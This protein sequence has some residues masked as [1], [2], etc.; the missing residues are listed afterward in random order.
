VTHLKIT[1]SDPPL[2][3]FSD[4]PRMIKLKEKH[5]GG[6][7]MARAKTMTQLIEIL[8]RLKKGESIRNIKKETGTHRKVIRKVKEISWKKEWL[9][10]GTNLPSEAEMNSAY[11]EPDKNPKKPHILD[12]YKEELERYL[13]KGKSFVVIHKLICENAACAGISEITVR[14][15]I[16]KHCSKP[17]VPVMIR[18]LEDAVMEVDFGYLGIVFDLLEN[19][20]KKAWVF[21]GRLRKSRKAYREI[22]YNQKNETFFQCHNRAFHHFGGVPKK[23]VPDNLKS[24]VVEAAFYDPIINRSYQE[25]AKHYNFLISPCL[26]R[27]PQHKGGVENDIKYIKNNFWPYFSEKQAQ[28]GRIVPLSIELEEELEK[29]DKETANVRTIKGV[30]ASPEEL[31]T[32][33]RKSLLALPAEDWDI[34]N[35]KKCIVRPE[36]MIQYD[37]AYYSVPYRY[38]GKEVMVCADS[39]AVRV[40]YEYNLIASHQRAQRKW[41]YKRNSLHAPIHQEEYL[42]ETSESLL[43]WA[44]SIG[45]SVLEVAE[46]ILS[47]KNIDGLRPTRGLLFLSKKY[48]NERLET[49]CDRALFYDTPSYRSVKSILEKG[50]DKVPLIDANSSPKNYLPFKFARQ[51]DYFDLQ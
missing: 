30:G 33:E 3:I 8:I 5:P 48:S 36:W 15:Y 20:R 13:E 39:K 44:G 9:K 38:I 18:E 23:V 17:P 19:R 40:F 37:N 24:A 51:N 32:E 41:E 2:G 27:K 49:A 26:P 46:K 1:H 43:A 10:P 34:V 28:K 4:P 16:H 35:W 14:R 7:R 11:N 22:V 6:K 21:S 50:L 42:S 12:T 45:K 29:W 25:L 31:F 47:H